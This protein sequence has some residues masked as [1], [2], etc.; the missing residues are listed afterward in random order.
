MAFAFDLICKREMQIKL[1][2]SGVLKAEFEEQEQ[3]SG[4]F[5]IHSGKK[6]IREDD[7]RWGSRLHGQLE[8]P[9]TGVSSPCCGPVNCFTLGALEETINFQQLFR[10]LLYTRCCATTVNL[11]Q[12][13]YWRKSVPPYTPFYKKEMI[14]N[15]TGVELFLFG[16][17]S[18][19]MKT[20]H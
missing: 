8:E 14:N 4:P 1:N 12:S 11:L 18:P 16:F 17:S 15:K 10:C 20:S 7:V 5:K 13:I 2:G 6:P 19:A 9:F 3:G